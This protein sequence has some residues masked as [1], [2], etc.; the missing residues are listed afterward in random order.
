MAPGQCNILLLLQEVYNAIALLRTGFADIADHRP[1]TP[2]IS[3]SD[4]LMSA[5]A[6]APRCLKIR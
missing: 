4:A 2:K 5:L 6:Y 1:G 3:L